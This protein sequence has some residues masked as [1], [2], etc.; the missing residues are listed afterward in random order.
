MA[1]CKYCEEYFEYNGDLD[2]HRNG[3]CSRL[4]QTK[5]AEKKYA[6]EAAR[7]QA[8]RDRELARE[9]AERDEENTRRME[10]ASAEAAQAAREQAAAY[11]R[12]RESQENM[13]AAR[14]RRREREEMRARGADDVRDKCRMFG[15]EKK[16]FRRRIAQDGYHEYKLGGVS[17]SG[18]SGGSETCAE[19]EATCKLSVGSL[20]NKTPKGS[21]PLRFEL[22]YLPPKIKEPF[23]IDKD[24]ES[25]LEYWHVAP[26]FKDTYNGTGCIFENIKVGHLPEDFFASVY[27]S[28]PFSLSADE[29][30][31]QKTFAMKR[32]KTGIAP[33][34]YNV[35]AVLYEKLDDG[36]N[37]IVAWSAAGAHT[38]EDSHLRVLENGDVANT[39]KKTAFKSPAITLRSLSDG[40]P[41]LRR[42]VDEAK[43]NEAFTELFSSLA[44]TEIPTSPAAVNKF[45]YSKVRGEAELQNEFEL[46]CELTLAADDEQAPA[47]LFMTLSL[48]DVET[49]S[50]YTSESSRFCADA[51]GRVF[52]C[53]EKFGFVPGFKF[54]KDV[55]E[56]IYDAKISLY[57]LGADEKGMLL[58][59]M[60]F[61]WF[62]RKNEGYALKILDGEKISGD[63]KGQKKI[64]NSG[65][66]NK[67]KIEEPT[68]YSYKDG[69]ATVKIKKLLN[70]GEEPSGSL[71]ITLE[72]VNPDKKVRIGG[73][74]YLNHVEG[75]FSYTDLEETFD[76]ELPAEHNDDS[77][78]RIAVYEL[79]GEGKWV[80]LCTSDFRSNAQKKANKEEKERKEAEA[81]AKRTKEEK[82]RK[83][84]DKVEKALRIFLIAVPLWLAA[85]CVLSG[86]I[87][88]VYIAAII[89]AATVWGIY[90]SWR[91]YDSY[92]GIVDFAKGWLPMVAISLWC[93]RGDY[94]AVG[95]IAVGAIVVGAIV[96]SLAMRFLKLPAPVAIVAAILAIALPVATIGLGVVTMVRGDKIEDK[97]YAVA[98]S[99]LE[100][101][102]A[103]QMKKWYTPEAD[104]VVGQNFARY[105][106]DEQS[107]AV[108]TSYEARF[109]TNGR[110][111]GGDIYTVDT[112]TRTINTLAEKGKEAPYARYFADGSAY[113]ALN[114][115]GTASN[116]YPKESAAFNAAQA[117]EVIGKSF[118]GKWSDKYTATITFG[119]DGRAT[120]KFSDGDTASGAYIAS[121][122]D[123]MVL[124]NHKDAGV[125]AALS[126]NDDYSK[127]KFCPYRAVKENGK[128]D[129]FPHR[130]DYTAWKLQ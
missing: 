82:K 125:W 114:E 29:D 12:L 91:G 28:K 69:K 32:T 18:F 74:C 78:P 63:F 120:V 42:A 21:G 86:N 6:E 14:Q 111:S 20:L 110:L 123:N 79:N 33:G 4:C 90:C 56:G 68:S 25:G 2:Y 92:D 80:R 36:S 48:T 99:W 19:S 72:F 58:D 52:P 122:E 113:Y 77:V 39:G 101:K 128:Y 34:S 73:K 7:E 95:A 96:L 94:I 104:I 16:G 60:T 15:A 44:P 40:G 47:S 59:T 118:S 13:E 61:P 70:D 62:S 108:S 31:D 66:E 115:D 55:P 46:W 85:L 35:F 38:T 119:K 51:S 126:Y 23:I 8:E 64:G 41:A 127:V 102:A 106:V 98:N 43:E 75:G 53:F 50:K 103:K 17:V 105:S 116:G 130:F 26:L 9:Q 3:Y 88:T 30:I 81:A 1:V 49:G 11:E 109:C 67:M 93:T 89:I 117:T 45:R 87:P 124:Y 76:F 83:R 65:K 100:K 24:D 37:H 84:E 129:K 5:A 97:V 10:A 112:A 121:D 71:R 22:L 107:G 27:H 54:K 57:E